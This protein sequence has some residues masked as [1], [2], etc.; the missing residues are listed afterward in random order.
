MIIPSHQ[1]YSIDRNAQVYL[2]S[3]NEVVPEKRNKRN[4]RSVVL[5]NSNGKFSYQSLDRLMLRTYGENNFLSPE[6][7]LSVKFKD[8]NRDNIILNNISWTD[9]WYH[10][11]PSDEGWNSHPE[12]P[13]IEVSLNPTLL[14]RNKKTKNI[15]TPSIGSHGY[16][17]LRSP[18][19]RLITVHRLLATIFLPHPIDTD[20]LVVNHKDSNKRNL[21]VSNLEW[22]TTSSNNQHAY[23]EG[24]RLEECRRVMML[25]TGTGSL[26]SCPSISKAAEILGTSAG[27]VHYLL[28]R[29]ENRGSSY[30]GFLLKYFD[31]PTP[32]S[33][34]ENDTD[35]NREPHRIVVRNLRTG[36]EIIYPS[37]SETAQQEGLHRKVALR[38][39]LSVPP[40]PYGNG[41]CMRPLGKGDIS[42]PEYPEEVLKAYENIKGVAIPLIITDKEGNSSY[43]SSIKDWCEEDRDN[44]CDPAVLSRALKKNNKWREWVFETIDLRNYAIS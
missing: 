14:I 42:W 19:E 1:E 34:I 25:E 13:D 2:I 23:S 28:N 33:E 7:W 20:H 6:E 29:I 41:K 30:K 21:C 10:P 16:Y 35:K 12:Y 17:E 5:R 32:W 39:L 18:G 15:Y 8:G 26:I 11:E 40:I 31:D 37:L 36:Q 3:S 27:S 38:Y 4:R 43:A 22:S 44:R 9:E 24:S